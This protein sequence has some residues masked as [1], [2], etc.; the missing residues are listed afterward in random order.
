MRIAIISAFCIG[1]IVGTL[2]ECACVTAV[3]RADRR[4]KNEPCE[5]TGRGCKACGMA[6][7]M[8]CECEANL[9]RT[10]AK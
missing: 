9:K 8:A 6:C 4:A 10:V 2:A 3:L 5:C 7:G 1:A